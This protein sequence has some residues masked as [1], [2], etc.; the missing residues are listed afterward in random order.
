MQQVTMKGVHASGY[1]GSESR[2]ATERTGFRRVCMHDVRSEP[3]EFR[4]KRAKCARVI[5][6]SNRSAE[7]AHLLER[8]ARRP[9]LGVLGFVRVGRA[10]EQ[11]RLEASGVEARGE[12]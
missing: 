7:T 11:A 12:Y 4:C 2:D 9:E 6:W 1:P 5:E 3:M 10:R 8:H